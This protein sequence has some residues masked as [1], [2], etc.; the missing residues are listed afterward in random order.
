MENDEGVF[1]KGIFYP[2][3]DLERA[4]N[5]LGL[6]ELMVLLIVDSKGVEGL[7]KTLQ[8]HDALP[9]P[10]REN[11]VG[12]MWYLGFVARDIW[13]EIDKKLGVDC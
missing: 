2:Y 8:K 1:Y 6:D 7:I 10:H 12:W 11:D 5:D 9:E 13:E 3:T 4:C